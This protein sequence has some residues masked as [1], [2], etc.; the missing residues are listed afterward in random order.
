MKPKTKLKLLILS[1]YFYPHWTGIAKSIYNLTKA[2]KNNYSITVLTVRH[3]KKLKKQELKQGVK[4][5]RSDYLFTL[6]RSKYSLTIIFKLLLLI[7]NF[8]AVLINTP[9]ANTLPFAIIAKLFAKKILIFHQGDLILPKSP[10][11]KLIEAVFYLSHRLALSLSDKV[12]TYTPDYAKNSRVLKPYLYKFTPLL[13]PLPKI[14]PINR[15]TLV[16]QK[17]KILKKQGKL[18]FGFAGRF[19]EEKGFDILLTALPEIIKK[20]PHAHFVFAGKTQMQYENF[21]QRNKQMLL[22]LKKHITLLGL[23]KERQMQ[24]F[25]QNIDFIV[26]PSRSDCF[27]LVQAEAMLNKIPAISS[28]ISGLRFAVKK[29]GFGVLFKMG[30]PKDLVRKIIY[31]VNNRYQILQNYQKV[32]S[33]FNN[34]KITSKLQAFIAN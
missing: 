17:L 10:F 5:I 25:Y 16:L 34:E 26:V 22:R 31:A 27:N 13:L 24:Y 15:E 18:L 23:L 6:S 9:S 29:T 8:D 28:D 2:L 30:N 1:D 7:K 32:I 21:Y 12:A 3:D 20:L 14:K 11:N 4:I 33:F 19:V